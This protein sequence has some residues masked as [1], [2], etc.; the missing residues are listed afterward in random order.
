MGTVNA[1]TGIGLTGYSAAKGGLHPLCNLVATQYGRHGVRAN[2]ISP[3]TIETENRQQELDESEQSG[4][5]DGENE[6]RTA[7]EEWIDQYP[8]GRFGRPDEVAEAALFLSSEHSSFVSGTDL[9]VDEGLTAGLDQG[10]QK[11]IYETDDGPT[12]GD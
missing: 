9:V 1:L 8:L 4:G 11:R 7:H 12:R 2:V 5:G 10:F 3:G 6:E